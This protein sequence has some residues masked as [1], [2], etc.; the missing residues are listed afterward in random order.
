MPK[1]SRCTT[2]HSIGKSIWLE[3]IFA[4]YL[5][6]S[7]Y[8]ICNSKPVGFQIR[9]ESPIIIWFLL[10]RH[11]RF[12]KLRNVKARKGQEGQYASTCQISLRSVK[13]LLKYIHAPKIGVL[14]KSSEPGLS[15]CQVASWSIQPFGHNRHRPG[16][17]RTQPCLRP[18]I[19][20]E[21]GGV[22]CAPFRGG[23]GS[24]TN[25]MSPG[26]RPIS[27][28]SC[29]LIHLTI[30]SQYTRTAVYGR[31]LA[32]V[33]KTRKWGDCYASFRWG[34]GSPSNTMSLRFRDIAGFVSKMP[35]LH[36]P[37]V[38]HPKIWRRSPR[39]R[40]MGSVLHWTRSLG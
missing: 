40:S 24:Q 2:M 16:F 15:P 3:I 19:N 35:L 13:P 29:I 39:V 28:P 34:A 38:F 10:R 18:S 36:I 6:A 5:N 4:Y 20:R 7:L 17:I 21:S 9:N 27:V 22:F 25:T 26:P 12:L 1:V 11:L 8:C 14:P 37:L 30:S 23:T 33:G 31:R 32:C